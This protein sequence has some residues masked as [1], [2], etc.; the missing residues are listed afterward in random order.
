MAYMI[1]ITPRKPRASGCPN[2]TAGFT[3]LEILIA[4]TIS[5]I[6]LMAVLSSVLMLSKSGANA[7]N[8]VTMESEARRGLEQFS[9]DV[10]MAYNVK[11]TSSTDITLFATALKTTSTNYDATK[12]I[13]YYYDSATKKFMRTGP[14]R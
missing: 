8:Y 13:R 2:A 9:E 1:T 10:R 5:T 6:T 11:W 3:V 14:D 12:N 4:M 7:A